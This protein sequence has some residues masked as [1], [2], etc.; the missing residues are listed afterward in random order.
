MTERTAKELENSAP[1]DPDR[2]LRGEAGA[3]LLDDVRDRIEAWERAT[4]A[5]QRARKPEDAKSF[6]L[7]LDTFLAN[8]IGLWLNRVDPT[9]FLAV[10]F[11]ANAYAGLRLSLKAMLTARDAL[12][13]QGL[14]EVAPGFRKIDNWEHD[15][16]FSR[17]TRIRATP[18]LIEAFQGFGIERASTHRLAESSVIV[19][20][21]RASHEE[22]Q[23]PSKVQASAE[24]LEAINARLERTAITLPDDAWRRIKGER[25][26]GDDL[27]AHRANAGD[28]AA[29]VL[30]RIFS[31]TWDRGGRIYGGWWM[32]VPKAERQHIQIDGEPVVEWD[33]SHLHPALLFARVGVPLDF[34]PYTLAGVD[35]PR[36]RELG[37][38]T[39][40][41]LVNRSDLRPLRAGKDDKELMPSGMRFPAYL[42]LYTTRLSPIERWFGIGE[43][44]RLQREDSDLAVN[45]LKR[46]EAAGAVTLPIHDSFIV[47]ARHGEA[48]REAMEDSYRERYEAS[49]KV[50]S[51]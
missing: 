41:R 31:R 49:P 15:K 30:R 8:L 42:T 28:E 9:R 2:R 33:Y 13:A 29:K 20:R 10:A 17:R 35:N 36:L 14:I 48:L 37:K 47:Q 4:C 45:V 21:E 1:F 24:V 19:I 38:R 7:T 25:D 23:P 18:A 32:H 44:M 3:A 16:P 12:K 6:A 50:K 22:P 5:R 27:D 39:F 40:Q 26:E 46:M 51:K 43:G 11:D 34:D